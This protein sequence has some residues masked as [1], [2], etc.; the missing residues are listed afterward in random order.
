MDNND[1]SVTDPRHRALRRACDYIEAHL[2]DGFTLT[3]L[4]QQACVSRFHFARLFRAGTGSS[5]MAYVQRRRID[6]AKSMLA[7]G[8]RKIAHTAA[9]LGFFDQSHFTRTF[10]RMTGVSPREYVQ[11]LG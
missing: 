7:S 5:P 3:D 11:R 4:A 8:E 10:R 1:T 9:A 2:G 6:R